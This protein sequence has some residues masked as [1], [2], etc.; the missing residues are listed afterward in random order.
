MTTDDRPVET[1]LPVSVVVTDTPIE[2]VPNPDCEELVMRLILDMQR[3]IAM[4]DMPIFINANPQLADEIRSRLM[5]VPD[6]EYPQV[7]KDSVPVY[8][9]PNVTAAA[10][11]PL[12]ELERGFL[13]HHFT[14]N[15]LIPKLRESLSKLGMTFQVAPGVSHSMHVPVRM[16]TEVLRVLYFLEMKE[17]FIPQIVVPSQRQFGADIEIRRR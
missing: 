17:K 9:N 3:M 10:I 16:S 6:E 7:M 8:A 2:E 4:G 1:D 12:S 14:A 13:E 5:A 15:G 11:T